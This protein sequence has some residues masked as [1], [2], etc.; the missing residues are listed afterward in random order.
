MTNMS[1][2]DNMSQE[3]KQ[4]ALATGEFPLYLLDDQ[5]QN[6]TAFFQF[7]YALTAL[8]E[9]PA[10]SSFAQREAVRRSRLSSSVLLFLL[11][12]CMS[13]VPVSYLARAMYPWYMWLCLELAGVCIVALVLLR[14]G[15]TNTAGILVCVASYLTIT[16]SLVTTMPFDETT[17]QGYDMYILLLLL[18]V[19]LLPPR[20]VFLFYLLSAAAI[21]GTLFYMPLSPVLQTDMHTRMFLILIRPLGILFSCGGVAYIAAL[22]LNNA[23]RRANRAET[24]AVIEHGQLQ[25][26]SDLRTEVQNLVT[27]Q[28]HVLNGNLDARVPLTNVRILF[29]VARSL[30][31]LLVRLQR[32]VNAERQLQ[33]VDV[34]VAGLVAH[35]QHLKVERKPV[36]LPW[37]DNPHLDPLIAEINTDNLN[38]QNDHNKNFYR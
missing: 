24:V 12:A 2:V 37:T 5:L 17:L 11:I 35:I 16:T 10:D 23:V 15:Y 33:S 18:C 3:Q 38:T 27:T 4:L 6:R 26:R 25:I 1:N 36:F 13:L 28:V 21:I 34:V 20:W 14:H 22:S 8:P 31:L 32:A 7:W 19:W 30:N 9:V 29:Q